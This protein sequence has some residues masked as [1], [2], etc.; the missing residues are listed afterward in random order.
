[1]F[2][3]KEG[4]IDQLGFLFERYHVKVYNYFV[5]LTRDRSL[6]E[7]LTQEVFLRILRFRHTFK[8]KGSFAS[9]MFRIARNVGIDF[10]R[11]NKSTGSLDELSVDV[12]DDNPTPFEESVHKDQINLLQRA[13]DRLAK[14]HRE[15]L[16]LARFE[17][18]PL[19]DVARILN[20]PVNTAKVRVHRAVK[21]LGA[22]YAELEGVA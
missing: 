7:D 11:K 6:S 2:R 22:I 17:N 10:F 20:C 3:V 15:V 5:M 18:L 14:H 12:K 4:R 9:W 21:E 13:L 19:K 16:V 8:G 1:M